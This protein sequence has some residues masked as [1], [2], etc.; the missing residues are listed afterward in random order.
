MGITCRAGK[1][2]HLEKRWEKKT[3][4]R[5]EDNKIL[6]KRLLDNNNKLNFAYLFMKVFIYFTVAG[7]D[8]MAVLFKVLLEEQ[9]KNGNLF[10]K[11]KYVHINRNLFIINVNYLKT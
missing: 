8:L 9:Q 5:Q 10:G 1:L 6:D 11:Y 4:I 3:E 2:F 7:G